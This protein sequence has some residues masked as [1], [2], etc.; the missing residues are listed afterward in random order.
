MALRAKL[1]RDDRTPSGYRWSSGT[2]PDVVL[3]SGTRLDADITTSTQ[4]PISLVF[5]IL[6]A[7]D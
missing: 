3:S 1:E 5:T 2:G 7:L 4:H 6:N